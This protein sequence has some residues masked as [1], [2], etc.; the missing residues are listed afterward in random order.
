[1]KTISINGHIL[2]KAL[3]VDDP[4]VKR[5][6]EDDSG[7]KRH[8]RSFSQAESLWRYIRK[9]PEGIVIAGTGVF[10]FKEPVPVSAAMVRFDEAGNANI[11]IREGAAEIEEKLESIDTF[12]SISQDVFFG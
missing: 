9:H 12:R 3:L 2:E 5:T 7:N 6:Y 1:M 10:F 11:L 8:I 4:D